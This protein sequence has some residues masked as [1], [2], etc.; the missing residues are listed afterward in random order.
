MDNT[1]GQRLRHAR[2]A[3]PISVYQAARETKIR[4][5]FIEH[6]ESDNFRF[7]SGAMY[8]RG[9]LRGYARWL[10]L[11][12]E[13]VLKEFDRLHAPKTTQSITG[14]IREPAEAPK[15]RRPKWL[16]AATVA[17]STLL[18]L[19]LIGVMKPVRNVAA[20]PK[21]DLGAQA[22]PGSSVADDA[23]ALAASP[24]GLRLTVTVTGA[25]SWLRVLADGSEQAAFENTLFTGDT[26]TF[27]A[28]NL[29]RVTIGNL[30]SVRI[31]LNGRDLGAPGAPGQ[32]GTFVF[33]P[34]STGFS[35]G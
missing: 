31:S 22:E 7:M 28:S 27:E 30:G 35:R 5:D 13:P 10:G 8:V 2:E 3:V 12:D 32:F 11:D 15:S 20:P 24:S 6:M 29:L 26:R 17:A 9:M 4:V 23:L 1:I 25:K 19:S 14:M 33:T 21:T 34:A 18:V 16:I